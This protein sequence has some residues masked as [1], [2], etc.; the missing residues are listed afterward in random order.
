MPQL[1]KQRSE[2]EGAVFASGNDDFIVTTELLAPRGHSVLMCA[3]LT[4]EEMINVS[5]RKP[6]AK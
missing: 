3:A 5:S 6:L 4:P 2:A 1:C